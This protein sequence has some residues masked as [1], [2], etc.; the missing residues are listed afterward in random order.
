MASKVNNF[1]IFGILIIFRTFI[2]LVFL[3]RSLTISKLTCFVYKKFKMSMSVHMGSLQVDFVIP[4]WAL[5]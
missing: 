5:S 4:K 2:V 1:Y 3:V